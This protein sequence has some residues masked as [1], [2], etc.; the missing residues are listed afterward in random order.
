MPRKRIVSLLLAA[1]ATMGASVIAAGSALA[2]GQHYRSR[3]EHFR[4]HGHGKR[5]LRDH[6]SVPTSTP[7]K[8]LVVIFQENV[9]FDH[10]FGTYPRATNADGSPFEA[11]RHTPTVNGLEGTLLTHN[12]NL[13]NPQRL[14]HSQALTCDQNHGYTAEQKAYDM[15]LMDKFVQNTDVESCSPPDQTAPNLVMD[16]Y[17]GNTVTGLWNYAQHF[18]MS[19]NSYSTTFGPS[20]PGAI[21]VT[22]GNTFGEICGPASSGFNVPLCPTTAPGSTPATPGS[23]Q[24]Q[25]PGTNFSDSDPFYDVC[26]S[27]EDGNKTGDKTI[28]MGGTN[29]GDLLSGA[30]VSWGWFQ[31]G[32]ASPGYVSGKPNTDDLSAVCTGTSKNIGGASVNDYNVH[33]EPFQ[34]YR[35]TANPTHLPPTSIAMI[36]RQ[37]QANH[38]YDLRDFWAAADRGILPSVSYLKAAAYQDGS[39]RLLGPARRADVP[40]Q[41]DQRPREAPELEQHRG[42][43]PVRRQ[44]WVVRPPDGSGRQPVADLARRAERSG[45]VRQHA[46]RAWRAGQM[47]RRPAAAAADHLTVREAQLRGRHVH[48]PELG[49]AVHRGQLAGQP[50]HR[51]GLS[52]RLLRNAGQHVQVRRRPSQRPPVPQSD[53]RR[54]GRVLT[55]LAGAPGKAHV[56]RRPGRVLGRLS[57]LRSARV[58]CPMGRN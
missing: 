12:P 31:G 9:S 52:G 32:F 13:G 30:G 37:D 35:S 44:R 50:A 16:Y 7:I 27:T 24:A 19:D 38:Q 2:G 43:H 26:S 25:G 18:A 42:R 1:G 21:N 23:S 55:R 54:T 14:S 48:G 28:Q 41:Y 47:R 53:D 20:T 17:D 49:R 46:A 39:R 58:G 15:G 51:P 29:V 10:Y 5:D 45:S 34:Y 4:F 57:C 22:S 8:H 33:H 11:S 36:G 3:G 6:D 56:D 40:R